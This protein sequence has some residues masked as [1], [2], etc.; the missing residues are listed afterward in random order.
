MVVTDIEIREDLDQTGADLT[1]AGLLAFG[2]VVND[3]FDNGFLNGIDICKGIFGLAVQIGRRFLHGISGLPD[4]PAGRRLFGGCLFDRDIVIAFQNIQEDKTLTGDTEGLGRLALTHADDH[5]A[6]FP[7][8]G[9]QLVE[10]P[11]TGAD[12]KTLDLAGIEDIHGVY[13]QPDIGGILSGRIIGLHDRRQG[14]AGGLVE[15]CMQPVLGPV[16]VHTA[17]R[18][19]TVFGQLAQDQRYVFGADIIGVN[20]QGN[21]NIIHTKITF[22]DT[23]NNCRRRLRPAAQTA[24]GSTHHLLNNTVIHIKMSIHKPAQELPDQRRISVTTLSPVGKGE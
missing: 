24:A 2:A 14:I 6:G 8:T 4:P 1:K 5:L 15:P 7:Q 17:D 16:P 22:R 13:D 21:I 3:H 18:D 9:G 20:Q 23:I 19:L 12:T 11:V 10:I